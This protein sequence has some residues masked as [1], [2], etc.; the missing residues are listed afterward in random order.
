M[1]FRTRP[2]EIEAEQWNKEGDHAAV[3]YCGMDD[4]G[5]KHFRVQSVQGWVAVNPG[6]WIITE[7]DGQHH[8]P[9]NPEVF[10]K[11]YEAVGA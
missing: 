7:P 2:F 10:A 8:Y 11:K 5:I 4:I 3:K 6:D 1:K 9:C